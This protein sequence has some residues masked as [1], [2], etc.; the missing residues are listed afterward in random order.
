MNPAVVCGTPFIN[1]TP[2][3]VSWRTPDGE[4]HTVEPLTPGK[5]SISV[6]TLS[7]PVAPIPLTPGGIPC[8]SVEYGDITG[9]PDWDT[10]KDTGVHFIVSGVVLSAIRELR[11]DNESPEPKGKYLHFVAPATGPKDG[12]ER[13]AV[14]QVE[15]VTRWNVVWSP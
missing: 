11:I 12:A 8:Q 7:R 14:G 9:L 3:P 15:C 2:H 10:W 4:L 5:P 6:E 13:N 1:L